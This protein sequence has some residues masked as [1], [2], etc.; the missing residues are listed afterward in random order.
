MRNC[1][2]EFINIFG[3]AVG[4]ASIEDYLDVYDQN[5]DNKIHYIEW[6]DSVPLEDLHLLTRH[7]TTE[8]SKK[9][10]DLLII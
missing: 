3:K 1:K 2:Q 9:K 7:C 4:E 8:V 10:K 6:M 5:K